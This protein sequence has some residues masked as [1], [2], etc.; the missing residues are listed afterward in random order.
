M[1]RAFD[2]IGLV[3]LLLICT[4]LLLINVDASTL[5]TF[6]QDTCVELIQVCDN[7]TYINITSIRNPN[8]SI[9]Y[10]N[11]EMTKSGE[12][13]NY[14]FCN[15]SS[16]G[17][18]TYTTC[19]D[20][21]NKVVCESVDFEITPTGYKLSTSQGIMSFL[22]IGILI[23]ISLVFLILTASFQHGGTKVFFLG[24]CLVTIVFTV[25]YNLRVMQDTVGEFISFTSLFSSF[26]TLLTILLIG[27][28]FGLML[29]LVAFAFTSF[30]RVRGY[31]D[32]DNID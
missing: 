21:D 10:S 11:V 5:G 32:E 18:Y 30:K 19:G 16:L 17:T 12:E 15:T 27:A 31:Y 20:L 14:T 1:R 13:Y 2:L 22:T 25:G 8:S 29:Y 28:G 24:L 23:I 26:Y 6:Q 9:V 3:F 7:C 4:N